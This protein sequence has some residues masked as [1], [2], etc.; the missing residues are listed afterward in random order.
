M[1][2]R[3]PPAPRSDRKELN[4]TKWH[5][6]RQD[7]ENTDRHKLLKILREIR[8]VP[9]AEAKDKHPYLVTLNHGSG[10]EIQRT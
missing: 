3:H 6:R 9:L 8:H 4:L 7:R 2:T 5:T 10:E 1:R